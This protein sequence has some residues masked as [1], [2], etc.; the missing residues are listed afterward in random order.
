[1]RTIGIEYPE[2]NRIQFKDIGAP[3]E[4]GPAE[5]L[6]RTE[7]SGVTN[8]TE[9]HA[10]VGEHFWKGVFP[11][12]HGYQ[13]VGIVEQAGAEAAG[14]SVGDRVF[15]GHYVGHRAWNVV[16]VGTAKEPN[17][18]DHLC[19]K[20]PAT[21]SA[22]DCALFGVAGVAL[23]GIRRMRV[24]VGDRVWIVGQGLIGQFAAQCAR[25]A[26]AHVVASDINAKRLALTAAHSAHV[27]LNAGDADFFARIKA[28]GPFTHIIDTSGVPS[29]FADLFEHKLVSHRTVIGLLAVRMETV[30]NWG[31]LH[32]PE[33]SIEVSCHFSVDELRV[34]MQLLEQGQ[35]R[36]APLITH[37]V[38]IDAALPVY[39][40]LRDAPGEPLGIVFAW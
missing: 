16:H 10:L 39:E 14:F 2:A 35:I 12:A 5:I 40:L 8:G 31:L 20:I 15:F 34:L 37:E 9:R 22:R 24:G 18:K 23:R 27:A 25:A 1:M 19:C 32:I 30:F 17:Y 38:S 36:V 26:G 28:E 7:Y 3:P 29:L 13:H 6:I 33:A 21:V 11:S 4:P